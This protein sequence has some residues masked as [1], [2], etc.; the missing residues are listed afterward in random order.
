MRTSFLVGAPSGS[1]LLEIQKDGEEGSEDGYVRT[2]GT[3][4]DN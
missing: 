2:P 4:T 3:L 1:S